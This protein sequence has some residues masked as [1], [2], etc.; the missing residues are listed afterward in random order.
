MGSVACTKGYILGVLFPWY[1]VA[2]YLFVHKKSSPLFWRTSGF[3]P[4][5]VTC[6]VI[7]ELGPSDYRVGHMT[8]DRQLES[9][10]RDF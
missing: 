9:F 5:P 8:Q 10:P 1:K 4:S 7:T 6:P 2:I 3:S